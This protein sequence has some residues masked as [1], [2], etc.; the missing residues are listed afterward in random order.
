[1]TLPNAIL[2]HTRVITDT[3]NNDAREIIHWP[4]SF[5]LKA[6]NMLSFG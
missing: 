2:V 6:K 1:M 4:G 3:A 5:Q